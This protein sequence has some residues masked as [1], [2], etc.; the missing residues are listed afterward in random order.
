MNTFLIKSLLCSVVCVLLGSA[1]GLLS[2]G[3][4]TTWYPSIIKPEWNPPAW[5][6]G[7]VWTVLYILMGIAFALVWNSSHPKKSVAMGI[8][9]AQFLLNLLWTPLFFGLHWMGIAFMEILLLWVMIIVT[10]VLFYPVQ[11]VA[12]FLLIPYL[13]WV[14]F[15]SVLNGTLWYLNRPHPSTPINNVSMETDTSTDP[16]PAITW[17]QILQY[18]KKGNPAP[19]RR[20]VKTDKE[21]KE[22]LTEEQ[23]YVLRK[24]GTERPFSSE[25][26]SKFEPGT[27]ACAGCGTPLFD[28]TTKF[29]SG[30]G[31]PSFGQPLK[32]NVVSYIL[33]ESYGMIRIEAR[34]S[35]CDGHLGHV[36]PDGPKPTGLRYCMNA[37]SLRKIEKKS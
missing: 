20:V 34:C 12:A 35:I 15:A 37:L 5:V 21:W 19:D 28:S 25:M 1:S 14:S 9:A 16:K 13:A 33:D 10:I 36:F 26:C 29:D 22:I 27:Y 7:P 2:L 18:A 31:W 3:S 17:N 24:S 30:T 11:K 32:N 23:F 6:F 4:V 8:F